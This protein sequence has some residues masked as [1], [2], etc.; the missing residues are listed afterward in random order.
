MIKKSAE[1]LYE[2]PEL[3]AELIAKARRVGPV[4]PA[5]SRLVLTGETGGMVQAKFVHGGARPG[6]GRKPL[7]HVRVT[8]SLSPE[9]RRRL[10][11]RAKR[12]RKTMSDLVA[13][14][15]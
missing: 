11:S 12:E 5:D 2:A 13:G 8:L 15:L 1:E 4:A 7:G 10:V 9:A 14:L 3:T 6:S